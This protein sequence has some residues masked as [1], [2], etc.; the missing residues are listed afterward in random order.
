MIVYD[1]VIYFFLMFMFWINIR[2]RKNN[3]IC[4]VILVIYLFFE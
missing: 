4:L 1:Y 2:E 3:I